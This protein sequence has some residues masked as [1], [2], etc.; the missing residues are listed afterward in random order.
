MKSAKCV[1]G[2]FRKLKV[3][4]TL[5]EAIYIMTISSIHFQKAQVEFAE[6]H[7]FRTEQKEPEYLLE[8][9]Y[10]KTN[11]YLKLHDEKELYQEQLKLRKENRCRGFAPTLKDV[12]W[13][14]VINL[15]EN[16][17]LADVK[18]VADFIQQKYKL[19]TCSIAIHHDEGYKD[20]N[21]TV[22]YNNHAHLCFLTMENG[23]S[24][25]RKIRSKEL[26]QMQTEVAQLLGMERGQ[27]NSQAVRL[28]HKQYR[29]TKREYNA[30]INTISQGI[31]LVVEENEE[32]NS[33][34]KNSKLLLTAS[35]Q[36]KIIEQERK[37][38]IE[39]NNHIASEYRA[40]QDLNKTL[41]TQEELDSALIALREKH[42][43][44][45]LQ[46]KYNDTVNGLNNEITS[47]EQQLKTK[48]KEIIK[49]REYTLEEIENLPRVKELN[50][51]VNNLT[52]KNTELQKELDTKPKEV[53]KEVIK[54][55]TV[56]REL[57][58][59]E[60]DNLPRVQE[61]NSA[62]KNYRKLT[63]DVFQTIQAIHSDF[64]IEHPID[65]L[66][67]IYFN[68][69]SRTQKSSITTLKHS[70]TN[71][72][73]IERVEVLPSTQNRAMSILEQKT[74]EEKKYRIMFGANECYMTAQ[75]IR[76]WLTDY[77]EEHDSIAQQLSES[78]RRE[79][80]NEN[81]KEQRHSPRVD[82]GFSR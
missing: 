56:K 53:V 82:H 14:A 60:I 35:E 21:D 61:L 19:Q 81:Q 58:D 3:L 37:K 72:N 65:S 8:K 30:L 43:N 64:D 46:L 9:Q 27:V 44:R 5:C 38:Y 55:V 26:R 70:T 66:K 33:V 57:T 15:N 52:N 1:L 54:T 62:V 71:E 31:S 24:T 12:Y 36:K 41:H 80:F 73:T 51:T 50:D 74:A 63:S 78:D 20:K 34:V 4:R 48:P 49:T 39:D 7:N 2:T 11:E 79:V 23:I 45:L 68:W 18:K 77:P 25:M 40:L 69:K 28:D 10:R 6:K 59:D 32:L 47:L 42:K 16:H 17:S 67:K 13:E 22:K 75:D 29:K 76:D